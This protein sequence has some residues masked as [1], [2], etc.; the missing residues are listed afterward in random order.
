MGLLAWL[1]GRRSPPARN[2]PK[3]TA[4]IVR[5]PSAQTQGPTPTI[6]V[7]VA[8]DDDWTPPPAETVLRIVAPTLPGRKRTHDLGGHQCLLEYQNANGTI[9]RRQVILL[10]AR[11]ATHSVLIRA[12][13][14][15]GPKST[16]AEYRVHRM[17][18]I[19]GGDNQRRDPRDYLRERL[20]LVIE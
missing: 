8:V 3:I 20:G 13:T 17:I 11:D 5:S 19:T 7:T 1:F 6:T 18:S 14:V 2:Q 15:G 12:Y 9:L 10:D 4:D 16:V